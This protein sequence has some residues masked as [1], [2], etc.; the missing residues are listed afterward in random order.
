[1]PLKRNQSTLAVSSPSSAPIQRRRLEAADIPIAVFRLISTSQF[2]SIKELARFLL[3]TSKAMTNTMYSEDEVWSLFLQARFSFSREAIQK[4]PMAPKET[5]LTLFCKG[6]KKRESVPIR[7]PQ[8]QPSDYKVIINIFENREGG[9]AICSRIIDGKEIPS[10]FKD[11]ILIVN[12]L[13][14]QCDENHITVSAKVIR[15]TDNKALVLYA[16]QGLED[17]YGSDVWFGF[18]SNLEVRN[19]DYVRRLYQEVSDD[20]EHITG[21]FFD[22]NGTTGPS[23]CDCECCIGAIESL[24]LRAT[25]WECEDIAHIPKDSEATFAHFLEEFYGWE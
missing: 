11:G 16:E 18:A 17:I 13:Q 23:D 25:F 3:C 20:Y 15:L 9:K 5:F 12:G 2:L 19:H 14:V 8:Y 4:L 7:E 21:I 24:E 6:G 22:L 10:F 1:M